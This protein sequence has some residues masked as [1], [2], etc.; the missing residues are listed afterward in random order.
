MKKLALILI[1]ITQPLL[2]FAGQPLSKEVITSFYSA[3]DQLDKLE[4]KYPKEFQRMDDFSLLQ[5]TEIINFVKS[6]K[7]YPDIRSV[8][9]KNGFSGIEEY[10]DVSV[11]LMGSMYKVQMQKMPEESRQ[12]L[13]MMGQSFDDSI[14]MMKQNGM[15]ESMIAGMKAQLEDMKKQQTEMKKAA[16]L[17][18]PADV[19]FV[20]DNFD[21]VMKM[22]PDDE[23]H[24]DGYAAR[25]PGGGHY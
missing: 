22:M 23:A 1:F 9:S 4:I 6:S 10:V 2:V 8:M 14:K 19:K 20:S 21:W 25:Q 17:A 12:Q 3:S 18:S 16:K 11:R 15:P 5:Q 24:D 13:K 7:S